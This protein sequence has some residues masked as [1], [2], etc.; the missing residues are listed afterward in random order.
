M[1]LLHGEDLAVYLRRKG[2]CSAG[3]F[4]PLFC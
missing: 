1:E 3:W 2:L 4:I